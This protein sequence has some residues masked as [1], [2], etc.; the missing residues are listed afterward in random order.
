[1]NIVVHSPGGTDN[2]GVL[3]RYSRVD[4]TPSLGAP[5]FDEPMKKSRPS[6][7]FTVVPLAV[8]P[9][10]FARNPCTMISTPAGKSGLAQPAAKQSVGRAGIDG[11]V[12]HGSIRPD[13]IHVEPDMR[14][15]IRF[16]KSLCELNHLFNRFWCQGIHRS[17]VTAI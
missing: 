8:L 14:A 16:K 4:L 11:P 1:M 12:A 5:V 3:A 7:N 6:R 9:P 13:G 15:V 17:A 2:T 10:F